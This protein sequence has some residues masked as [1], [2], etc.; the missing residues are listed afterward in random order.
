MNTVNKE[1]PLLT[2]E[3]VDALINRLG[4]LIINERDCRIIEHYM[5]SIGCPGLLRKALLRACV[6]SFE[7]VYDALNFVNPHFGIVSGSL[8]ACLIHLRECVLRGEKIY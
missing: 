2:L 1:Y 4:N 6:F 5:T 3:I 7:E 8:K